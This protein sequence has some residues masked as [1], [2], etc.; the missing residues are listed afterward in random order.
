M[1]HIDLHIGPYRQDISTHDAHTLLAGTSIKQVSDFHG[2]IVILCSDGTEIRAGQHLTLVC[3]D[4][5][6]RQV[7]FKVATGGGELTAR[8]VEATMRSLRQLHA[9]SF[10]VETNRFEKASSDQSDYEDLLDPED[11]LFVESISAGSIWITLATRSREA[12]R[13]IVQIAAVFSD[14]GRGALIRKVQADASLRELEVDRSALE[15]DLRRANGFVDLI[16]KIERIKNPTVRDQAREAVF[17]NLK[18]LSNTSYPE[19]PPAS[20]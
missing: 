9:V 3:Q 13:S 8:D 14:A 7:K 16:S 6:N 2:E 17:A 18:N 4:L 12:F 10:L 20:D 19:I 11:R 5:E 1:A 15:N